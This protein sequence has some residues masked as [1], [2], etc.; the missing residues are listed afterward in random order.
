M[1]SIK[2]FLLRDIRRK[3]PIECPESTVNMMVFPVIAFH[4]S[5]KRIDPTIYSTLV[6]LCIT[7]E[8]FTLF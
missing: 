1:L 5:F 4:V 2:S 8:V 6:M 3:L 7:Q